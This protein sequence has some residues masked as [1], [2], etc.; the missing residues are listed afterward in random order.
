MET[1]KVGADV[2]LRLERQIAASPEKVFAAWTTAEGLSRWFSPTTDHAVHVHE[3]DVRPGGR[4]RIE[5][6]HKGGASHSCYGTYREIEPPRRLVFTWYWE[7]RPG[8]PETTVTVS[9]QAEGSGSRLTLLHE[10]FADAE[11]RDLHQKGWIGCLDRL[12]AGL[13]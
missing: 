9:I 7:D 1:P 6:R 4:Y 5:M 10:R 8:M 13:S 3:L 11:E 12:P 2:T